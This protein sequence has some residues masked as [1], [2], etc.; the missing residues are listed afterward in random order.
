MSKVF[1]R[2]TKM[3]DLSKMKSLNE[4]SLTENYDYDFWKA[5]WEKNKTHS[6][7]AITGNEL[8]G[9]IFANEE[10]VISVAVD[11]RYRNKRIGTELMKHVLNSYVANPSMNCL[12]LHVRLSNDTAKKL[13][14]NLDFK[15]TQI[16]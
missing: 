9:Y 14:T 1:L 15:E 4:R 10:T 12:K 7:V 16:V 6:F 13:Y 8:I 5:I 3:Q 11:D 2:K